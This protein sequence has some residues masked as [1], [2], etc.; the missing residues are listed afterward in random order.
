LAEFGMIGGRTHLLGVAVLVVVLAA[1]WPSRKDRETAEIS[2][3]D[4]R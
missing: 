3:A 1:L 4:T 2:V